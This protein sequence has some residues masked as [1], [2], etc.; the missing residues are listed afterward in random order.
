MH[1]DRF[2]VSTGKGAVKA[3]LSPAYAKTKGVPQPVPTDE[4]SAVAL[5]HQLIPHTFY[6]RIQRG[7]SVSGSG[8]PKLVQITPQQLFAPDEYYVWLTDA[9]QAKQLAMAVAMVAVVLAA[10]MFPLWPTKMRIGVWYLSIGVLGLI[11]LFFLIAIIR[12]IIWLV[13]IVVAK[14][15]IWIFPNL[16]ADVGFVSSRR[17]RVL[18]IFSSL[19]A[20]SHSRSQVD[21]FIPLWGW[22]VPPPKKTRKAKKDK[23]SKSGADAVQADACCGGG[24]SHGEPTELKIVEL[25]EGDEEEDDD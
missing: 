3:I 2:A 17:W 21:S 14:P 23:K 11:G 8:T 25:G 5:L 19:P 6:L 10:V 24:H 7:H 22:D 13:T 4:A 16:F 15:G 9:N 20:H 18:L 1:A 12:L